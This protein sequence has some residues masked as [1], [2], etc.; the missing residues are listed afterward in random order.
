MRASPTACSRRARCSR[1]SSPTARS[2]TTPTPSGRT[3]RRSRRSSMPC[4][5][6]AS[7]CRPRRTRRG[8]SPP[9]TTTVRSSRCS[10]PCRPVP[11]PRPRRST[12]PVT[13][14]T[15]V[16]DHT[17]V[18]LLRHG[19]VH[20]PEGVLYGRRD[21]YH[22]SDLGRQMAERVAEVIGDRDI[23]HL[24]SSPLERAQET[25]APLAKARGLTPLL[26]PRVIES[27]NVFEGK[28]FGHGDNALRKPSAWIHLWNPIKP[29]WGEPYKEVVGR[30]L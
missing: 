24:R 27:G 21:G 19:E 11:G 7:T 9:P 22:L 4:S 23:V 25:A 18:H 5:T 2:A 17:T 20:N 29:S 3:R 16:A 26:D 1:C 12:P 30:M 10:R 15:P 6:R 8:S 13:E 28:R 14:R